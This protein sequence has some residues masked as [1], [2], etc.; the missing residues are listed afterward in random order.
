VWY[1]QINRAK[2]KEFGVDIIIRPANNKLLPFCVTQRYIIVFKIALLWSLFCAKDIKIP[3]R[4]FKIHTNFIHPTSVLLNMF[5]TFHHLF[6]IYRTTYRG[7]DKS[8]ARPTS[9]CIS[10]DGE[11]VSFDVSLVYIL[12]IFFQL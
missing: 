3:F 8:L 12:L 5:L 2:R 1:Y 4:L 9:R 7:A 11:N 10:F 6:Y